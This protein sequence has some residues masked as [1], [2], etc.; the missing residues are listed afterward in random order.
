MEL[1]IM[2][3]FLSLGDRTAPR[4][5]MYYFYYYYYFCAIFVMNTVMKFKHL[6][7]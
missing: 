4:N 6:T 2:Y 3:V 5:K 7:S 1:C